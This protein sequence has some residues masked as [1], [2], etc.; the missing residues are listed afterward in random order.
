L[1][2]DDK[3]SP[4]YK[5]L[6]LKELYE[7]GAANVLYKLR[8]FTKTVVYYQGDYRIGSKDIFYSL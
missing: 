4:L 2:I 7:L 6:N 8:T 5:R 1:D 3:D